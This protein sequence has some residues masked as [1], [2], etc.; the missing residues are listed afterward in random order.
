MLK[1]KKIICFFSIL[2]L[3]AGAWAQKKEKALSLEDCI[4]KAMKNNLNVAVEVLNPELADISVSRATEDFLPSLSFGYGSQNTNSPS[5][6]FIEAEEKISTEYRDYSASIFQ[7]IP[8]GGEFSISL[9]SYKNDSNQKFL[10]INPRYSSTLRFNFT[11]PL[12]KNFGFK[13]S[14]KEIIIAKN[15]RDI[16]ESQLKGVLMDT[17]YNVESA[18]WNFVYSIENLKAKRQSLKLAQDLL[19]KNKREVEVGTFAPIE[20]LSA[21]TE[22][23]SRE[24]D[25]LQAEAMVKNNEDFLKTII[26]LAAEEKG[27]EADIIPVDKPAFT[28]KEVNLEDAL[29]TALENRPDLQASRIDVQ[30]KEI[31]LSYA[32]NQLLPDLSLRASYWSPGIS[33]TKIIYDPLDP[34]GPPIMTIPGGSTAALR[35]AFD[36]KYK[37]WFVGLTL[38]IPLNSFLS[39]AEYAQARVNLEQS[40]FRLKNQEQQIFLEI[41]NAVRGVQTDYKRVHAYK[42]A[43]ELAEK[44][45]EAEEK[46]LKVGLTTNYVVLQYQRDLAVARSAELQAIIDYNLSLARLDKALGTTLKNKNIRFSEISEDIKRKT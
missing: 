23:A 7:R 35:D 10:S 43:R 14:R 41:K 15:N 13:I 38:S 26:N 45:L 3:A 6:S 18:Y 28:K 44:K 4:L 33:G 8:T 36:F 42:V 39:R 1:H 46:K 24:A 32:R 29:L 5:F 11:Q 25:I 37:N 2:F 40:M 34:F 16:S 30:N 12:L 20:I 27:V 19:A 31:N 21:Q 17:I 22:V 9:N